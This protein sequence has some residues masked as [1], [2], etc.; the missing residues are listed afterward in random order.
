MSRRLKVLTHPTLLVV[1][2]IGYLPVREWTR[3]ANELTGERTGLVNR[4]R[5]QLWRYYSQFVKVLNDLEVAASAGGPMLAQAVGPTPVARIAVGRQVPEVGAGWLNDHVWICAGGAGKP[6][7]LPR[8][9][10][11]ALL[12]F[13]PNFSVNDPVAVGTNANQVLQGRLSNPVVRA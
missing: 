1:D 4:L 2:E 3:I 7:S 9:S 12:Q 10:L 13:L 6:A 5:Q 8:P 11:L